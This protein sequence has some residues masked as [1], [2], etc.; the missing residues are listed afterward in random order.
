MK[1]IK[2]VELEP[3]WEEISITSLSAIG[4]RQAD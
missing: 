4:E 1:T 2:V 3:I